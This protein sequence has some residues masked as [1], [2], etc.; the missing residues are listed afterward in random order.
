[1]TT[2]VAGRLLMWD[3]DRT[4]LHT[5]GVTRRA[6][7]AAFAQMTGTP[8][9]TYPDFAGRTDLDAAHEVFALHGIAEPD[10]PAFLRR[11]ATEYRTHAHLITA[12]GGR[13]RAAGGARGHHRPRRPARRRADG[14]RG[15]SQG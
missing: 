15:D 7:A 11:Y 10:V 4:L 14:Q 9:E 2:P 1:M 8:P 5:R 13:C 6:Y 12:A 3:I